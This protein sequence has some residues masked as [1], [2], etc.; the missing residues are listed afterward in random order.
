MSKLGALCV[1][2][3]VVAMAPGVG[4]AQDSAELEFSVVG[5]VFAAVQVADAAAASAWYERVLLLEEINRIDAEDGR[6]S[7]RLLSGGGISLELI[8]ERG[9]E[10]APGKRLGLFKFGL[11][12]SGIEAAHRRLDALG[13]DLDP[14]IFV[15]RAL[16][17]KSF[18]FRDLEGNRIQLFEPCGEAC[19]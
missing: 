17:V 5:P 15:D 18:V 14:Q 1:T 10:R 3:V 8:E 6:Y 13:V 11:Y 16:K 4:Q 9:L 19:Q 12:V 7:I 2:L